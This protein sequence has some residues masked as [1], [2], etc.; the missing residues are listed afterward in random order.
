[1]AKKTAAP[2]AET[3]TEIAPF[4][5]DNPVAVLTDPKK[6]DDLVGK[7]EAEVDAHV[8]D[9]T[10]AK[11][12]AAIKS[13][14]Y[15]V[16]R[17]KTALDDAGKELNAEKR[18]QIDAVDEVRRDVRSKLDALAEKARKP[19]DEWEEA[20]A[21]RQETVA[22]ILSSMDDTG[23]YHAED[24]SETIGLRIE[25]LKSLE[26]DADIFQDALA[27]AIA[28]KTTA[29]ADL[30]TLLNRTLKAEADA[31]EL[32][33]L[34]KA[35]AEREAREA[36][37]RAER[38]RQE[39]AKRDEEQRQRDAEQAEAKRL[40]AADARA[41]AD[42]EA[43]AKIDAANAETNALREAEETRQ[44]EARKAAEEQA[45][46]EA[47]KQH[48]GRIMK[49]A[50]EAIMEKLGVDEDK[51]REFVLLIVAGEIPNVTIRF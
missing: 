51:A 8:P 19:L 45:A 48:R 12:R 26:F 16:V 40:A 17:T 23:S 38:D 41:I 3:G 5:I 33:E 25:A 36:E 2:E 27:I 50:K 34:R 21:T 37:E 49:A 13:L 22:R 1:M 39:Q 44:A 14:A 31:A 24:T 29:L 30:D 7:I 28:K 11:G 43:Q 18:K 42:R 46:R 35:N 10:T 20:E 6:F 15:K 9:L 47:D 32:A 4:V